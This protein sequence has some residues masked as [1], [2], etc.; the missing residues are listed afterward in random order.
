MEIQTHNI[1]PIV[2]PQKY[3]VDHYRLH[4]A[5][6][7]N[8]LSLYIH[9][10]DII[11]LI[12]HVNYRKFKN[13]NYTVGGPTSISHYSMM[14]GKMDG[15]K[16]GSLTHY[17]IIYDWNGFPDTY[18]YNTGMDDIRFI[19]HRDLL[20]ICCDRNI[21]GKKCIFHATL[22]TNII[23]LRE[24]L[25]P[26]V[27]EKNWMPYKHNDK[28]FVIYHVSPFTIKSIFEDDRK[29]ISLPD[30]TNEK[31]QGYHG[32]TNGIAYKGNL[33]FLIHKWTEE[34]GCTKINH[35]WVLFDPDNET[36]EVS[37]AFSFFKYTFL[38]FNCSIQFYN[39][40]YY[41]SLA[42]NEDKI[43]VVVLTADMITI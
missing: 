10:D 43:Y 39:G 33:L 2:V 19:N 41:L 12:R 32:S 37:D 20:I 5:F 34:N 23:T 3:Y 29:V 7:E 22:D 21:S 40:L 15:E 24:R 6:F 14:V 4:N 13:Q 17:D 27:L 25:Q 38:E 35:R 36:V 11:L 9:N 28:D 26:S 30:T 31:L 16:F 1:I 18:A 8:N 42:I